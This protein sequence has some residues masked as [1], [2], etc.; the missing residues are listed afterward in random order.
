MKLT[1]IERILLINQFR[2]LAKLYPDEEEYYSNQC[3]VLSSGYTLNYE[4]MFPSLGEE[5]SEEECREVLE[6]LKMYDSI[7]ISLKEGAKLPKEYQ[8]LQ[9]FRGFDGTHEQNQYGYARYLMIDEG[10]Y[11]ELVKQCKLP[12]EASIS[13]D[14]NSHIPMLAHY[15]KML[16]AW[17]SIGAPRIM[18][19]ET[20]KSFMD[21]VK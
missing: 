6:I 1:K 2:I 14:V 3:E 10:R 16:D 8:H 4:W 18:D 21:I 9:R 15:R 5:M 20:L 17:K 11:R 13:P 7:R 19:S 12:G